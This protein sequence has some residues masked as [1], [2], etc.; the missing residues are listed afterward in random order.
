[1]A[2]NEVPPLERCIEMEG[3]TLFRSS[4][5]RT[6]TWRRME[7]TFQDQTSFCE[8][9]WPSVV[10]ALTLYTGDRVL[11]ED[12][13]QETLVKA[14]RDWRVI[15]RHPN[16]GAWLHKVAFNVANSYFRR[17]RAERRAYARLGDEK[18]DSFE[19]DHAA[20]VVVR[21][22]VASLP[23]R[24]RTALILRYFIDLPID[25]VANLMNCAPGTV[26]A[27]T[28]RAIVKLRRE[29]TTEEEGATR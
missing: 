28:N 20:D 4:V 14:L 22:V 5:G 2:V 12:L 16:P 6:A 17:K 11:A 27:L 9:H 3:T 8:A 15:H 13:A 21:K 26:K 19:N 1:M 23:R 24:Q 25:E 29:L 18:S 7:P 10:S